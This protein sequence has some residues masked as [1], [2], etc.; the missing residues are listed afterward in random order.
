M[1]CPPLLELLASGSFSSTELFPGG[2]GLGPR[3]WHYSRFT[4]LHPTRHHILQAPPPA[5][6]QTLTTSH[7]L[8][9]CYP[10]AGGASL[11]SSG[12]WP[13]CSPVSALALHGPF[14]TQRMERPLKNV[15][16]IVSLSC[17]I[18]PCPCCC[19]ESRPF[20][21]LPPCPW[22]HLLLLPAGSAPATP[23]APSLTLQP[24]SAMGLHTGSPLHLEH[25]A[26]PQESPQPGPTPPC[27]LDSNSCP[28]RLPLAF[29]LKIPSTGFPVLTSSSCRERITASHM[30][31][32]LPALLS[33]W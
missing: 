15:H 19:S 31:C 26:P 17:H 11:T 27:N 14:S 22:W 3:S 21:M 5:Y 18:P 24:C 9:G 7:G 20:R 10:G 1:P 4:P 25:S 12:F 2:S 16:Q 30:P 23:P 32:S 13:H 33:G 6:T 8:P 28:A 29:L